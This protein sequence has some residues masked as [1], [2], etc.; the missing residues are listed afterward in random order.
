MQ[1]QL[2]GTFIK[3]LDQ[4]EISCFIDAIVY[5]N[6]LFRGQW[7]TVQKKSIVATFKV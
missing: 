5:V 2:Q 7:R 1:S 4:A 3:T 6:L